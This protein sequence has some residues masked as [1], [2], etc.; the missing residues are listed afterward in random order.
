MK[1]NQQVPDHMHEELFSILITTLSDPV[2][3]ACVKTGDE[4]GSRA[5]NL[6]SNISGALI[7]LIRRL[8]SESRH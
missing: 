8:L 4:E 1:V 5:F 7:P 6:V 3:G 2:Q